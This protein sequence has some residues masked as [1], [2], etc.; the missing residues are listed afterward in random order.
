MDIQQLAGHGRTGSP[1]GQPAAKPAPAGAAGEPNSPSRAQAAAHT[2]PAQLKQ[3]IREIN[4]TVQAT[5]RDLEFSVDPETRA[6]VVKVIDHASGEVIR[7]IPAEETL[8]IARSLDRLQGLLL[9]QK[10]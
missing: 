5:A 10:A 1:S 8:E 2:N 6:T 4:Q 9:K 3:A 7:Q